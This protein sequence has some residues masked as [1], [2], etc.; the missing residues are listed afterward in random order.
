M[1]NYMFQGIEDR[2]PVLP[3]DSQGSLEVVKLRKEVG[4]EEIESV[5]RM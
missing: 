3:C 5:S 2:P 1:V 4:P